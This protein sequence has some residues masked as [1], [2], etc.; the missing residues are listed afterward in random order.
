MAE[1][2]RPRGSGDQSSGQPPSVVLVVLRCEDLATSLRF[3]E[4]LG[5]SFVEEQHGGGP[6]H[7][8][9]ELPSGLVLEL[10]GGEA[11]EAVV[12]DDRNE[13]QLIDEALALHG[14]DD[15]RIGRTV[16]V[17]RRCKP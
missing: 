5:L 14:G 2:A 13:V 3:Y 8:A 10:L 17:G 12:R 15:D 9:S 6:V 11:H 7:F 16:G 1:R 4:R